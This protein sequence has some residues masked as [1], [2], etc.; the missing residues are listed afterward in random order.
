MPKV[1]F[2]L[3][4]EIDV[5]LSDWSDLK[6]FLDEERENWSWSYQALHNSNFGG[7]GNQTNQHYEALRQLIDSDGGGQSIEVANDALR[8]AFGPNGPLFHS[9]SR[10]GEAIL[11]ARSLAGD[12]AGAFAHA[13]TV[14]GSSLGHLS[15][16]QDAIGIAIAA[17]P[18]LQQI[19]GIAQRL[20]AERANYKAALQRQIHTSQDQIEIHEKEHQFLLRRALGISRALFRKRIQLWNRQQEERAATAT[21][22]IDALA[23]T[24]RVYAEFMQLRAAVDYW[25]QEATRHAESKQ[26]ASRNLKIFFPS[27]AVASLILF[28]GGAVILFE[29]DPQNRAIMQFIIAGAIVAVSTVGFWAGRLLTKLYLSEHHLEQDSAQRAVMTSTYLALISENGAG[30]EERA[31]VLGALFRSTPDGIV[32]DDATTD[33]GGLAGAISKF[34]I[35]R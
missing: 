20:A 26:I 23:S 31:I 19:D 30:P 27:A 2:N 17:F 8:S 16:R 28:F 14:G 34:G 25:H 7:L 29:T 22:N 33:V 35:T 3:N 4:G 5:S 10:A 18:E 11:R 15:N 6:R 9:R 24:Q 12:R 21:K 13:T 32:K 1:I